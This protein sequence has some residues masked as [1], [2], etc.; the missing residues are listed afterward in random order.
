VN[1]QNPADS[2]LLNKELAKKIGMNPFALA[3]LVVQDRVI[4]VIGIDRKE[5]NG[6]INDDEFQILKIFANSAAIALKNF[7]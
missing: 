3:P 1:V 2:T 5:Q 4:G 6:A 7:L